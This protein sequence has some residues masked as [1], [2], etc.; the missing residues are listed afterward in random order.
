MTIS[1]SG[2]CGCGAVRFEISE[3]LVAAAYCHCTRCQHRTGTAAQASA[4][5]VDGSF[6]LVSGEAALGRWAPGSGFDKVFCTACGSAVF[7]QDPDDHDRV[8]VRMAAID[9]DPGVRPQARQFVAYA[10]PWEPIPDDGLPR[11]DERLPSL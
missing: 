8:M 6:R 1:L 2:G 10:A 4:K 9:G 5:T 3:P 11:F 7:A